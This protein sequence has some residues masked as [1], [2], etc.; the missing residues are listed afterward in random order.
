MEVFDAL[1]YNIDRHEENI[2]ADNDGNAWLIDH[3]LAIFGNIRSEDRAQA[4]LSTCDRID[5]DQSHFWKGLNTSS[6]EMK[7]AILG[8]RACLARQA[9]EAPARHLYHVGLLTAGERDAVIEF[10]SHRRDNIVS[11]QRRV[12]SP[13]LD[14]SD[15]LFDDGGDR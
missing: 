9:I 13:M 10:L 4:L 15:L 12:R 5:Y 7:K 3:D 1:I 14:C 11:I 8:V 6:D 2:L